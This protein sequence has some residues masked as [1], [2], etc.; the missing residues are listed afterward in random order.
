[1]DTNLNSIKYE[2]GIYET[3]NYNDLSSGQSEVIGKIVDILK[4]DRMIVISEV[5]EIEE[6]RKK[7]FQ[8]S[9]KL[10]NCHKNA[11]YFG[12][13]VS[14]YKDD[15]ISFFSTN[16]KEGYLENAKKLN[17]NI[18]EN[19]DLLMEAEWPPIEGLK[20]TTDELEKIKLNLILKLIKLIEGKVFGKNQDGELL[21]EVIEKSECHLSRTLNYRPV[22]KERTDKTIYWHYDQEVFSVHN[23][24]YYYIKKNTEK[25]EYEEINNPG[26]GGLIYRNSLKEDHR[27]ELKPH[28]IMIQ[29][30]MA[31]MLF[32]GRQF[33]AQAHCVKA[34][35]SLH[36]GRLSH[37]LFIHPTFATRMLPFDKN[38]NDLAESFLQT[39][40]NDIELINSNIL[41]LNHYIPGV[42]WIRFN[43]NQKNQYNLYKKLYHMNIPI[44]YKLKE[45]E[46]SNFKIRNYLFDQI[47]STH[48]LGTE[49]PDHY[50]PS[51][52]ILVFRAITQTA[53][54][55][56]GSN[57]WTSP[58]GNVYITY[59]F[60]VPKT[61]NSI[62]LP[63]TTAYSVKKTL[64]EYL[65]N[66]AQDAKIVL[67][68]IN[69]IFCNQK[70]ISGVLIT[71]SDYIDDEDQFKLVISMGVNIYCNPVESAT[72]LK[73]V[74]KNMLPD[75]VESFLIKF[76][77][78][79]TVNFV[80]LMK[81]LIY[82]KEDQFILN[83]LQKE[84][85]YLNEEVEI[86]NEL[87]NNVKES[88]VFIGLNNWGNA[89]L[90]KS[91]GS[92]ITVYEGRMRRKGEI[93]NI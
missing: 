48:K 61:F 41:P 40:Q 67:K 52:N 70:K 4:R 43:Q 31:F 62:L 6:A 36:I 24:D 56:Q 16:H 28:E 39:N 84:L 22:E 37:I 17:I 27:L 76:S 8:I 12:L 63:Q 44:T 57:T 20:D 87:F 54:R 14:E 18:E 42:P 46:I 73:E 68:W 23:Q 91:D 50:L 74:L 90:K 81:M 82:E 15:V 29:L 93:K 5:P 38:L 35:K 86:W 7:H 21:S 33:E 19:P 77:D 30:G 55:G 79:L 58:K 49:W 72:C 25:E 32:S 26:E 78:E 3:I 75:D 71:T 11:K 89:I 80:N 64:D 2:K 85:V 45:K 66:N 53:G 88:G 59:V 9:T 69:D 83:N 47:D 51:N 65:K 1:M 92:V 60:R 13:G 34:L 10:N